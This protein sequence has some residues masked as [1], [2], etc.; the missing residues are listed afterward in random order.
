MSLKK[1]K[2]TPMGLSLVKRLEN[3][4]MWVISFSKTWLILGNVKAKQYFIDIK[5]TLNYEFLPVVLVINY[6]Q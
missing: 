2:F 5:F 6:S 3:V 4:L 1:K